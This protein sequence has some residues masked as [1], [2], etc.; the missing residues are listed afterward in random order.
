VDQS[1]KLTVEVTK[2]AE[3]AWTG[4]VLMRAAAFSTMSGCTPGFM[5]MEG[6][7]SKG[8]MQEQMKVARAVPWGEGIVSFTEVV[9]AWEAEGGLKGLEIVA[10]V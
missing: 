8:D 1:D 4:E 7:L 9:R 3:E 6:A 5:N 2:A 10:N